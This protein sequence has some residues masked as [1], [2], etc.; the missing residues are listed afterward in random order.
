MVYDD[1]RV[2]MAGDNKSKDFCSKMPSVRVFLTSL[3]DVFSRV[4]VLSALCLRLL[5]AKRLRRSWHTIKAIV[6][7]SLTYGCLPHSLR[8][9]LECPY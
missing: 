6:I 8:G 4:D 9:L 7:R 2:I 5:W 1:I 3:L